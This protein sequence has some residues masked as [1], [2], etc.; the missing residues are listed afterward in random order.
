[1]NLFEI[2]LNKLIFIKIKQYKSIEGWLSSR[3]AIALYHFASRVS[4]PSSIIVEI[5]SWKGKSTYCIAK[6][7]SKGR[8][9][10]ID[11]FDASGEESSAELYQKQKGDVPL[12]EQFKNNMRRLKVLDKIETFIGY[13]EDFASLFHKIDLLFIDGDHSIKGCDSDFLNYTPALVS[14]GYLL[15]HDF[16]PLRKDLGPT[17]V[18]ENRIKT[19]SSFKFIDLIDSLWICRK[20]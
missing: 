16:D 2:I 3:E 10:V 14:N 5:G 19:S 9:A 4:S 15:L 6:G 18:T 20:I 12:V 8:I 7:L 1:M 13:S 17:W 11:P